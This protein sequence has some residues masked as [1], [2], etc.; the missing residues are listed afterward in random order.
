LRPGSF[1]KGKE[2]TGFIRDLINKSIPV[3]ISIAMGQKGPWHIVPVVEIDQQVMTVLWMI[4]DT[5]EK[6]KRNITLTEIEFRHDNWEGGQ[7]ILYWDK[8]TH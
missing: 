6:Q 2:K 5:L 3:L 8:Q 7:D 4:E 1:S